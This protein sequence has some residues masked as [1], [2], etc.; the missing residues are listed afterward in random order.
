[1]EWAA[2][3]IPAGVCLTCV[4]VRK[5]YFRF[6][7]NFP[8]LKTNANFLLTPLMPNDANVVAAVHQ[9]SFS[10]PW[11]TADFIR[12]A[13]TPECHGVVAWRDGVIAGFIV[14][15]VVSGDA[16][17]L[18]IAIDP[19]WRRQGVASSLLSRA[20]ADAASQGADALFLEVGVRN[21]AALALYKQLGF[22]R[23]GRRAKYYTTP[24]G[25][26]DAIVMKRVLPK[27]AAG[28]IA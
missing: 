25:P 24:D 1:M 20:M 2:K 23:T 17:I 22:I 8:V 15:C 18:T 19:L 16:E 13:N 6:G 28:C 26:E 12:F 3:F 5:R 27:M 4:S 10:H 14:I 21:E 9:R 7:K 11:T